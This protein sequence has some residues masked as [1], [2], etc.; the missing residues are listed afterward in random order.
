[1]T[2][3]QAAVA[4]A[5]A[6]V[7]L[8][9]VAVPRIL[10]RRRGTDETFGAGGQTTVPIGSIGIAKTDLDPSGVVLVVGEQW[11]ADSNGGIR[12]ADGSRVRVVRQDGLTLLVEAAPTVGE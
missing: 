3:E 7:I 8:A 10:Q 12:I 2:N 9:V 11:T 4:I 6:I 5:I 1:V